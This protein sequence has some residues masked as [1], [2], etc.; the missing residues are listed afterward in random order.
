[1]T[2]RTLVMQPQSNPTQ[3]RRPGPPAR[4]PQKASRSGKWLRTLGLMAGA[5][6]VGTITA[7]L[8]AVLW[9]AAWAPAP[10]PPKQA[11]AKVAPAT[12]PTEAA[13]ALL[14][15]LGAGD[16]QS[17]GS[18]LAADAPAAQRLADLKALQIR[19]LR[20]GPLPGSGPEYAE[21]LIWSEYTQAGKQARGYF[22]L[23]VVHEHDEWRVHAADGP[24][25]PRDGWSVFKFPTESL[26]GQPV[27]VK[28]PAVLWAPRQPEPD[29]V[30]DMIVLHKALGADLPLVLVV[31]PSTPVGWEKVALQGG[32]S[33][34]V[35][36][37]R[38][39]LE[40]LSVPALWLYKGAAG[41][42]LDSDA[43]AVAS[44]GAL[45]PGRYYAAPV[46]PG[47]AVQ[48]LQAHGL[49]PEK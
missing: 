29:L 12:T 48:A 25:A 40:E 34:P 8:F 38:G 37:V 35:W 33:G 24:V 44:L 20:G 9:P 18:L 17:V 16:D 45:D 13:R 19:P 10:P 14:Q 31:D 43:R 11:L 4:P 46:W 15:L 42:L 3:A 39:R 6:S 7:V 1:M 27:K 30:Q 22:Q 49:L 2:N 47:A 36:R 21:V 5:L 28:G 26:D 23:Q 32:W 41:V